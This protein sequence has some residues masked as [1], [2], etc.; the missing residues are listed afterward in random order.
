[1]AF[2]PPNTQY[3]HIDLSQ[4]NLLQ[5]KP[6]FQMFYKKPIDLLG[7]MNEDRVF[8][9]STLPPPLA[10]YTLQDKRLRDIF[11]YF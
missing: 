5:V 6:S 1:M 9:G 3:L 11:P 7:G 4:D 8:R 2:T 10:L